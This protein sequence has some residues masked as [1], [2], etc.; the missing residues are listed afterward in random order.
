MNPECS[1]VPNVLKGNQ[2]STIYNVIALE[3]GFSKLYQAL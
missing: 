2:I 3:T 1:K